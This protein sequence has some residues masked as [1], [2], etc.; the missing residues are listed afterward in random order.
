[1]YY[2]LFIIWR[3]GWLLPVT[4]RHECV[5]SVFSVKLYCFFLLQ[6]AL[7]H[8]QSK[9]RR[10]AVSEGYYYR[11]PAYP[12]CIFSNENSV[13]CLERAVPLSKYCKKRILVQQFEN[14]IENVDM[15]SFCKTGGGSC[16][17]KSISAL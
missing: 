5:D 4:V 10:I 17:A 7:L 13:K 16:L 2:S 12:R 15:H 8:R 11:A 14:G 3:Y 1:M 6:E 9:Q